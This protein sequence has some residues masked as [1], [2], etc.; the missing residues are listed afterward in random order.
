MDALADD[1]AVFVAKELPSRRF[2]PGRHFIL[3]R[4]RFS[5]RRSFVHSSSESIRTRSGSA[6]L[7]RGTLSLTA[8]VI[9]STAAASS[10][11]VG[12]LGLFI[13]RHSAT[14]AAFLETGPCRRCGYVC[15]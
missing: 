15:R 4:R 7:Y 3:F 13:V 14:S 2:I 1:N 5:S 9:F 6:A 11:S 8:A 12:H 10:L